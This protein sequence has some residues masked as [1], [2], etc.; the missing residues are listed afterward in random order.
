MKFNILSFSFIIDELDLLPEEMSGKLQGQE[1]FEKMMGSLGL[2]DRKPI[3]DPATFGP[4]D[5]LGMKTVSVS[6]D[7][8]MVASL[9][10]NFVD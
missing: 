7:Q 3:P 9:S 10:K 1:C 2:S 6:K 5:P 8:D 4:S